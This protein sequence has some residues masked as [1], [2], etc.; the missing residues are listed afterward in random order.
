MAVDPRWQIKL[1][2]ESSTR[3]VFSGMVRIFKFLRITPYAHRTRLD[4][5]RI[6]PLPNFTSKYA[7]SLVR[8]WC[9]FLARSGPSVI[10]RIFGRGYGISPSIDLDTFYPGKNLQE[11]SPM[12]H[13]C[14]SITHFAL[15]NCDLHGYSVFHRPLLEGLDIPKPN[16]LT[17]S[18]P[19]NNRLWIDV[20]PGVVGRQKNT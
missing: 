17:T 14:I 13:G 18:R 16:Y 7:K 5:D 8:G 20:H 6:E 12:V 19:H 1:A 10:T 15:P 2:G 9:A 4:A 3:L 11:R